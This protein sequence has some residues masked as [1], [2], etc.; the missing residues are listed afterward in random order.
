MAIKRRFTFVDGRSDK[1]WAVEVA[2]AEVTVR[3]GRNGTAGQSERKVFADP[4]EA[5]R[6]AE[7][8]IADKVIMSSST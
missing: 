4:G 5:A 2:G 1:F 3:F 6:H 7:K 8:R